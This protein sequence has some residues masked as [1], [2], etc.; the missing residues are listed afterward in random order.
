MSPNPTPDKVVVETNAN[1]GN[2]VVYDL[3]GR[4]MATAMLC[5]GLAELDLSG[6][7]KG[8]YM[9]QVNSTNGATTIKLVKE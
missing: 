6:F 8:I 7:A 3:S 9:A 2:I 1:N 4:K 5:K